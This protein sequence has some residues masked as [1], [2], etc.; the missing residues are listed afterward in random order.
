MTTIERLA[1]QLSDKPDD[2][3]AREDLYRALKRSRPTPPRPQTHI[4]INMAPLS[5]EAI[6]RTLNAM[7]TPRERETT[8]AFPSEEEHRRLFEQ[9]RDLAMIDPEE[10]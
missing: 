2:P 7:S 5:G 10:P 1:K 6:M 4:F 8:P 3:K 9:A